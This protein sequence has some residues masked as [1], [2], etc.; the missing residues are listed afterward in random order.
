VFIDLELGQLVKG[1][2]SSRGEEEKTHEHEKL[3][4]T[5]ECAP[6]RERERKKEIMI[7][8]N[9]NSPLIKTETYRNADF[10]QMLKNNQKGEEI[11]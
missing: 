5:D 7:P 1:L 11:K 6:N 3:K 9:K 2:P 8:K 10:L 4:Q